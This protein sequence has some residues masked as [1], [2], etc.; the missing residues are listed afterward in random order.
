MTTYFISFFLRGGANEIDEMLTRRKV[1]L[2]CLQQKRWRRGSAR[3]IKGN[4]TTY[5]FFWC[6]DQ[7]G[8]R[9]VGIW[10]S[11]SNRIRTHNYLVCKSTLNY[12][13]KLAN[14]SHLT[15][16]QLA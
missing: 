6:G 13:G 14:I 11:D 15:T 5:K 9:G 10:L 7:S 8:F 3:L 12:L 1:D 2:C 4:N 16:G